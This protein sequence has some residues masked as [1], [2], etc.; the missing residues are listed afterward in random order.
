MTNFKP[1]LIGEIQRMKKYNILGA[2]LVVS[3]LWIGVMYFTKI[4]DV[5]SLFPL[6]VYFEAISMSMLMIGVTMFFEK[7]E[8]VIKTLLVSPIS[9]TEYIMAK[10][11]SNIVSNLITFF[12]LYGYA[13]IFKEVD[14]NILW[15]TL[16]II[17]IAFF[18]SLI[19]FI[20]TYYSKD[21]TNL[22]IG[23]MKYI[24]VLM[25]PVSLQDLGFIKSEVFNKV[26]YI[27]PT[28]A[29]MILLEGSSGGGVEKWKIYFSIAYLV[30]ASIL[31]YIVVSKK[32]DEFAIKESGV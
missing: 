21:F 13:R 4:D 23:M 6:L 10:T 30:L 26:L 27:L 7:Q 28:K 20:L 24:F 17:L 11:F 1:L 9:K 2:S 18:H 14:I 16:S 19:G 22:L 31:I 3:L 8:G 15:F 25:I 32:F 12:L 5:T 29:S